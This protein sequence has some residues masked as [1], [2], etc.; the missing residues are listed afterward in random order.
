MAIEIRYELTG[1]GWAKCEMRSGDQN[2]VVTASYLSDALGNLA[3]ATVALLR[4]EQVVRFSFNEDR[5]E[6]RWVFE[7]DA[8]TLNCKVYWVDRQWIGDPDFAANLVFSHAG[9]LPEFAAAVRNALAAVLAAHGPAGY[10][11]KWIEHDFPLRA[12][13][14]ISEH[15]GMST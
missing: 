14:Q 13:R 2:A 7:L 12:F 4:G 10:K 9:P 6:Y 15:L 1:S 5:G 3:E 11:E 8:N